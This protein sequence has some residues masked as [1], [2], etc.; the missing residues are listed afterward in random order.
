MPAAPRRPTLPS[1]V[2]TRRHVCRP[3]LN[4]PGPAGGRGSCFSSIVGIAAVHAIALVEARP[5]LELHR[6]VRPLT[7]DWERLMDAAGVN[8]RIAA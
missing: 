5:P 3:S 8:R 1:T 7:D 2:E 4:L 6:P